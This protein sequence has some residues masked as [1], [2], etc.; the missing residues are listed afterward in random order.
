[1]PAAPAYG[2]VAAMTGSL[3]RRRFLQTLAA[4]GVMPL[5]GRLPTY[6][7]G[8]R[9]VVLGAGLAGL[10]AAYNLRR[11]GYDVIVLEAQSRPGGRV[12]TV[13]DGFGRGGHAE[14]GAVRIFET[15]E[16]T[17]KY[18][19]EFGLELQPYDSGTRAFHLQG[20]RFLPPPPGT[21]WPLAGLHSDEQPDPAAR[22]G[23]YLGSGFEKIGDVFDP[24]WPGAS[25]SALELD[26]TTMGG[27][28]RAQ[29]ASEPWLDWFF[30]QEGRVDRFNGAA[31]FAVEA[32]GSG[33]L[34]RSIKGGNDRL[35]YAF[36]AA[37]GDRVKYR[38]EV[39]RIAAD[40]RGLTIGYRDRT[41]RHEI[42]ADRVVCA[43]PFAP[44]RRVQIDVPFSATKMAAIRKLQYMAV[45]RCY[46]QTRTRFWTHDPLGPLGGLNL[47]G[48]D[49]MAGRVWNT[50][51]QQADP[52]LGMVLAY[53]VDTEALEFASHGRRRVH[54]MHKLFRRLLP[55]ISGQVVG[56]AHKAW[57]EDPWAGGGWGWTQPGELAWMFPA[58]RRPEHRIHFAGE[59]TSL[60]IAWM[61]GALESGERVAAE[62]LAA[63]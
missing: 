61:N 52:T 42:H 18:V 43:L 2:I 11:H 15:H 33:T 63:G 23:D 62:I 21:P 57:Q 56:V 49:T 25:E 31:G 3:D 34:V 29:G 10:S 6:G 53:M 5:T 46:F 17:L 54:A 28:M 27:Y 12:Y 60:W 44:L 8:R 22:F 13:R 45:A 51:A 36:A 38:S 26:R 30:A 37:L 58:M 40:K 19:K 24:G 9:I 7:G 55:G 41:G 16:Y 14:M 39:L 1:M 35:P 47:V 4:A 48:T 32:I 20:K 50:S 59:H